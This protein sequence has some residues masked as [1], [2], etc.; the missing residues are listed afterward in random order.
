MSEALFRLLGAL[1]G[2][3]PVKLFFRKRI[4]NYF[5]RYH[6]ARILEN[7]SKAFPVSEY[8]TAKDLASDSPF[9]GLLS[10]FVRVGDFYPAPKDIAVAINISVGAYSTKNSDKESNIIDLAFHISD[11]LKS[12]VISDQLL[13]M[14]FEDLGKDINKIQTKGDRDEVQEIFKSKKT[15]FL[16]YYSTFSKPEFSYSIK[17]WHQSQEN[18]YIDWSEENALVVYLDPTRIRE[19]FFQSGFDYYCNKTKARL[20]CATRLG[21]YEQFN[22]DMEGKIVWLR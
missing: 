20:Q 11:E 19:G 1:H 18:S 21:G 14:I 8:C 16:S 10:E 13:K 4:E 5:F 12:R 2:F 7:A 9:R 15:I 22:G 17:V 6:I 3:Y